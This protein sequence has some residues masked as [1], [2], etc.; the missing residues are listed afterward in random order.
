MIE[1]L[2]YRVGP[3]STSDDPTAYRSA[4]E[5]EE[6]P[7][8]DPITRLKRHL[9]ALGEWSMEQQEQMESRLHELTNEE[10]DDQWTSPHLETLFGEPGQ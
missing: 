6:W 10:L 4:Q 5:R 8:G 3:H 1:A 2:T 7:L 9:I